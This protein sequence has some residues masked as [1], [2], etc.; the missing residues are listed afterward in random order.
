MF[1]SSSKPLNTLGSPAL[2][3]EVEMLLEV[4]VRS[5]L[6]PKSVKLFTYLANHSCFMGGGLPLFGIFLY[7]VFIKMQIECFVFWST[8]FQ[9]VQ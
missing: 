6:G 5:A 3:R 4:L 2:S 7:V 9:N 1:Q 8:E